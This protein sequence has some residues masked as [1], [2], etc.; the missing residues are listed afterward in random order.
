MTNLNSLTMPTN[1]KEGCWAGWIQS[2]GWQDAKY[3]K[4]KVGIFWRH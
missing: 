1:V 3:Q 4:I 2:N